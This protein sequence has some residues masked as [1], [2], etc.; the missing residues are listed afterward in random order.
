[1]KKDFHDLSD[2]LEVLVINSDEWTHFQTNFCTNDTKKD[3]RFRIEI[4]VETS[5]DQSSAL[6]D[7]FGPCSFL[8]HYDKDQ[9]TCMYY[10]QVA[11]DL[12]INEMAG[13]CHNTAIKGYSLPFDLQDPITQDVLKY[14]VM[15]QDNGHL[16]TGIRRMNGF[17]HRLFLQDGRYAPRIKM[18]LKHDKYHKPCTSLKQTLIKKPVLVMETNSPTLLEDNV[19]YPVICWH[20]RPFLDGVKS[21]SI[22]SLIQ[23]KI[24][25]EETF[26][27]NFGYQS[28]MKYTLEFICN[29]N[30]IKFYSYEVSYK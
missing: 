13:F 30:L 1:M 17:G 7:D 29:D 18:N 8:Y 3:K 27:I 14:H 23:F 4:E 6:L 21:G 16:L 28:E 2:L 10:A 12:N 5:S 11:E 25:E 26:A 9:K 24:L 22:Y 20:E 19:K 15:N